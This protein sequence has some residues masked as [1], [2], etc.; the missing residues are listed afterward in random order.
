MSK[1]SSPS[2]RTALGR[3]RGLGS[4][5]EGTHH[6][7]MQRVTS[8]AL[9]PLTAFFLWHLDTLVAAPYETLRAFLGTPYV[10]VALLLFVFAAYYH[11]YLGIQVI[12]ED[13]VHRPVSKTLSL[14][15]NKFFFAVLGAAAAYAAL[16]IGFTTF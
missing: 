3:A 9:I 8:I 6:W 14:L 1:S 10:T 15:A 7:W 12:I 13:Y 2:M 4:A 16:H 5:H 11:A